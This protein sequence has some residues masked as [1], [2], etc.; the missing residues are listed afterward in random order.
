MTDLQTSLDLSIEIGNHIIT[1]ILLDAIGND[2]EGMNSLE[3][4]IYLPL[5]KG[6][7]FFFAK[8]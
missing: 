5:N 6:D 4:I 1:G 3:I 7:C 8:P 2:R